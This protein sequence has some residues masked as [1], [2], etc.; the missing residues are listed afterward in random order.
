[1][2]GQGLSLVTFVFFGL[3][4]ASLRGG[5]FSRTIERPFVHAPRFGFAAI[6]I[7]ALL[8]LL[9]IASAYGASRLYA[10][11][12]YHSRGIQASQSGDVTLARSLLSTAVTLND[13]DLFRRSQVSV[14][15][16]ELRNLLQS[17][18]TDESAQQKFQEILSNAILYSQQAISLN[19]DSF[20]NWMSNAAVYGLIVPLG[21][22]GAL[23]N[24]LQA[25]EEARVRSPMSPE[26]DFRIA[27]L[28][29]ASG[30]LEGAEDAV[31]KA[32]KLKPD[33]TPAILLSG[34]LA[35]SDGRLDDAI[36]SVRAAI[37]LEPQNALLLYQLGLLYIGVRDYAS[38]SGAFQAALAI[39][40]EYANA[41][42]YL[43]ETYLFLGRTEEGLSIFRDL[44]EKNP[45]STV[46]GAII[47]S[48]EVGENPFAE[49]QALPPESAVVEQ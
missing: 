16:M 12:V 15:L 27:E 24:A 10:G 46:L 40:S 45:D 33:Y 26:V 23:E 39:D 30:N 4:L 48:V 36:N 14:E 47:S 1:M 2:P 20:D 32:L 49:E 34:Q 31:S 28:L 37:Y 22:E 3:F 7:L 8:V 17:G 19:P 21:I 25:L 44:Y 18:S 11:A 5:Q 13:N 6:F 43:G 38:A 35:L 29:S 9:S 42:F 41:S